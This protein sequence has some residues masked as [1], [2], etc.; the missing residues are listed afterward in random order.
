MMAASTVRSIAFN[1]YVGEVR[2][3][4]EARTEVK[5]HGGDLA[6]AVSQRSGITAANARTSRDEN[7]ASGADSLVVSRRN[8]SSQVRLL[9]IRAGPA[10]HPRASRAV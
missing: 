1:S 9:V 8:V 5:W 4:S 10:A 3:S 7:G 6:V 2:V